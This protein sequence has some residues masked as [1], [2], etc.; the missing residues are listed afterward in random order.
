MKEEK[1]EEEE[2]EK[3]EKYRVEGFFHSHNY[4]S[5]VCQINFVKSLN[6]KLL[7]KVQ[8][9]NHRKQIHG[10]GCGE[11]MGKKQKV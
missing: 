1:E 8:S 4:S 6:G 5:K 3:K 11:K 9:L 2:E 7:N 10:L